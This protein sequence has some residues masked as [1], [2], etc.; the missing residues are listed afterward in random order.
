[1]LKYSCYCIHFSKFSMAGSLI[2]LIWKSIKYNNKNRKRWPKKVNISLIHDL[3]NVFLLKLI[4]IYSS[5]LAT[6][7]WNPSPPIDPSHPLVVS[8]KFL[9][10]HSPFPQKAHGPCPLQDA[11]QHSFPSF[12]N[13]SVI[14]SSIN[15]KEY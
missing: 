9:L 6:H 1:M 14:Y 13:P 2:S 10:Q 5:G 4:A 11:V 7:W 12:R 8:S 15:I 3:S